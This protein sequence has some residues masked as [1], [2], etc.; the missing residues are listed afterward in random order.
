MKGGQRFRNQLNDTWTGF[1]RD[2]VVNAHPMGLLVALEDI[3][4]GG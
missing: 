2:Y 3:Q 1:I 4:G